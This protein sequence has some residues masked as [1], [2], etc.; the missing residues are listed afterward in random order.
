MAKKPIQTEPRAQIIAEIIT[1]EEH[2]D[3]IDENIKRQIEADQVPV[4][5]LPKELLDVQN[6]IKRKILTFDDFKKLT[7]GM[8]KIRRDWLIKKRE[9]AGN[10]KDDFGA[11]LEL[12]LPEIQQGNWLGEDVDLMSFHGEA[13]EHNDFKGTDVIVVKKPV[14]KDTPNILRIDATKATEKKEAPTEKER[15]I[16]TKKMISS[17]IEIEKGILGEGNFS[18]TFCKLSDYKEDDYCITKS[19]PRITLYLTESQIVGFGRILKD[20]Q[21]RVPGSNKEMNESYLKEILCNQAYKQLENQCVHAMIYLLYIA[22]KK[23][24]ENRMHI[25]EIAK[26]KAIKIFERLKEIV[27]SDEE[28][29][30]L[31]IKE[32][33]T[34]LNKDPDIGNIFELKPLKRIKLFENYK[35]EIK[36]LFS[37]LHHFKELQ[38]KRSDDFSKKYAA[39]MKELNPSHYAIV[40]FPELTKSRASEPVFAF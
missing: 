26:Q 39:Y 13:N 11:F 12:V 27:F 36:S 4:K 1:E 25:D 38:N 7:E 34:E 35:K 23:N 10:E 9:E 40:S 17:L 14:D 21:D 18:E 20:G 32:I 30:Y 16:I 22:H 8:K 33:I 5:L 28:E 3:Q 37:W 29:N 15:E 2:S 24:I 31:K 6:K 19:A